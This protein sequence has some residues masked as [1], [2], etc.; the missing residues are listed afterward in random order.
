MKKLIFGAIGLLIFTLGS[1]TR[2]TKSNKGA[3]A[4]ERVSPI[5]S[6]SKP[7]ARYWWFA[8]EI[9]KEDVQFN[10][11]WL[12]ENG[13]GGVEIAWVYPHNSRDKRLGSTYTPR[14]EWLSPEWQDV[15]SY[16]ISYADSLGLACDL[17]MGT[18][19]PF[20]DSH[21]SY[22]QASQKYGEEERQM[23][24]RSWE[25]PKS[26]YVVDHLNEE[27]YMPY[28]HRLLDSFPDPKTQIPHSYF[29]DS[30]EV[31]TE[32]LWAEG[33]KEEFMHSYQYDISPF[34]DSLYSGNNE[35]Q[36]YDYMKLISQKAIKFYEN[37]DQVLN[38]NNIF[39]RGQCSGAP[40]DIISAYAH[41]DIPEGEA[42]LY[43]PEFNTIPASAALLGGKKVVSAEAF[44]CL[45][46]WPQN[47]IREEQT[48]DL[49]MLAD[50]LFANGVNHI[51]WHGKAHNPKDQDSVNFY[52]S[53]HLGR[54]GSL[55]SEI[56]A[57]NHYLASVSEI[58]K[59]GKS[60]SDIAVYLPTEEA[61]I[62]G[63][64]PKE[65]QFIWAW[66]YYE[67][68]YIYFPEELAGHH[69]IWINQE[70]LEKGVFEDNLFKIG[71][72]CFASLYVD[73]AYLDYEALVRI[74]ELA[75]QG[76]PITM[77]QVPMEPGTIKHKQW[78]L[79]IKTLKGLS[80][81]SSEFTKQSAPLVKGEN[82]P[83]YW[84]REMD[85]SLNIFF[86]NPTSK[87]IVFPVEYGQSFSSQTTETE[88]V[89]NYKNRTYD[90]NLQF[91]PYNSLLYKIKDGTIEQIDITF[92]PK[93]PVVMK[94]EAAS[95]APW[96]VK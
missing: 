52:A 90:L 41:M 50:A 94:R 92:K 60:Y 23:I 24:K 44:T 17:T 82:L 19:W 81:V 83:S 29:I 46:G 10:L 71:D 28:F 93:I 59:Q 87:N 25:Y 39:S 61:W 11:D 32:K 79:L 22:E 68:R 43:E 38:E 77:K 6:I 57:F 80:N 86:A 48:A 47:H 37:F 45:Y 91:D 1:C 9:K 70:F 96:L 36:L 62:K 31:E 34:M 63:M 21:V 15:V 3:V 53:V 8:S 55:A 20:G 72:A 18:L 69:P 7:Y 13:F 64:M 16:A 42:M 51:I 2:S 84:A 65:E 73:A 54:D 78:E 66:G 4:D 49:K 33:F 26:G 40:C 30:W 12:K 95:E 74:T 35:E 56:P 5:E 75:Q 85:N 76:L 58:M 88:I 67:M 27:N 14:Q 89:I